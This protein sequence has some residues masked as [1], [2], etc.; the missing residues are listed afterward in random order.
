MEELWDLVVL[1]SAADMFTF[2]NKV[3]LLHQDLIKKLFTDSNT[4]KCLYIS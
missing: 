3:V 2:L 1:L 4:T